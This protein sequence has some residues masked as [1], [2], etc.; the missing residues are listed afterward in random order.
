MICCLLSTIV[1]SLDRYL[2][3]SMKISKLQKEETCML[4][5]RR[6]TLISFHLH[7]IYYYYYF[8]ESSAPVCLYIYIKCLATNF[9]FCISNGHRIRSKGVTFS[10]HHFMTIECMINENLEKIIVFK[11]IF[12]LKNIL[13]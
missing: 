9:Q 13:K 6:T 2:F 5:T 10:T 3:G 8:H 1:A 11:S 4:S 7:I 12:Y